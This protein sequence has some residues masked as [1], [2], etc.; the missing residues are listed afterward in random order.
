[1]NKKTRLVTGLCCLYTLV[2]DT[3]YPV[4]EDLAATATTAIKR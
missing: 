4:E 3:N 1:M 2:K